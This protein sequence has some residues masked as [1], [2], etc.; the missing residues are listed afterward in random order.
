M[1]SHLMLSMKRVATQPMVPW[2]FN[3][4]SYVGKESSTEGGTAS[5]TTSGA[6]SGELSENLTQRSEED[7]E[8]DSV[9]QNGR[10]RQHC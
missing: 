10:L 5:G 1:V 2:S 4:M 8:L 3:T 6:I 7:I 9:P